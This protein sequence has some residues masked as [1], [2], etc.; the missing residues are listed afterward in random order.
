MSL[1]C[2]VR[3][4]FRRRSRYI[5]RYEINPRP[6]N[7]ARPVNSGGNTA[8]SVADSLTL[9][10]FERVSADGESEMG[11]ESDFDDLFGKKLSMILL[12]NCRLFR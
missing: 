6:V 10:S 11:S 12:K 9:D 4:I 1:C 3:R 5:N 2:P 8:G 7:P